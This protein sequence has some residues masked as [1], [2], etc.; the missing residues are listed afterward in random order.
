MVSFDH[1]YQPQPLSLSTGIFPSPRTSSIVTPLLK[2]P[3]LDKQDLTNYRL[4]SNLSI[5]S[6][7]TERVVKTRL[8]NHLSSN[9]LLNPYQSAYSK[10]HSTKTTLLSLHDHLSNA[11]AHQQI[12]F[13][14]LLDLSAAF[15]TI[16]HSIL[17]T[18][19][20][21]WFG[22]SFI[23]LSWFCSYLSSSS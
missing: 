7:I 13:L 12:S 16:D 9:S 17:L 4:I 19:L 10:D 15:D 2:K 14:C 11:T 18:W 1:K 23:S 22:I 3:S 20:S 5:I 21:T 6:K 8:L